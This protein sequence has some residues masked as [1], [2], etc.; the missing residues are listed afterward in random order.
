[1][2]L[3]WVED[4]SSRAGTIVRLGTRGTA[5]Y[6]KS[7]KVFGTDD[8]VVLH[9]EINSR[10]GASLLYWD[11]PNSDVRLWVENYSVAYLGDKCWQVTLNYEKKGADDQN[12]PDPLKRSRSFDTTGGTSHITQGIVDATF[13]QGE[14]RYAA[15]GSAAPNQDG[16]IGVDDD[17]VAGVDIVVPGLQWT[18]SYD[19]PSAYV[20]AAYIKQVAS[21]TGTTNLAAFRTF[22]PGEVLFVGCTGSQEWDSNRGDGPWSLAFRFTASPNAGDGQTLPAISI[23]SISNISKR[24]HEYMWVRYESAV[25]S[26]EVVKRPKFVYV[27]RVYREGDFSRLGIGVS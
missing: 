6:T 9:N 10:A 22:A 27:N 26:T 3:E 2:S 19:V 18:E 25:A 14:H 11:Y 16:A 1:M 13:P 12:E 8:D 5:S 7:Y 4:K 21:L 15:S 24:G 20:T 17:R 23:G